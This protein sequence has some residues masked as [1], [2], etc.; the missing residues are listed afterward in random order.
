LSGFRDEQ[1][2]EQHKHGAYDQRGLQ[3]PTEKATDEGRQC[4]RAADRP[5][6]A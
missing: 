1:R 4:K 2:V 3:P 5:H 6:S